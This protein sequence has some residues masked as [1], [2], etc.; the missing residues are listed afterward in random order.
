MAVSSKELGGASRNDA[1]SDI[2]MSVV[3]LGLVGALWLG[4][5]YFTN[6]AVVA[7]LHW[8]GYAYD[9]EGW[10]WY[11]VPVAFSI[12]E[13]LGWERRK[14]LPGWVLWLA[15]T[16]A[17]LDFATSVYG[18]VIAVGGKVVPLMN[19]YTIPSAGATPVV[20]GI[21]VSVI[22]TFPPERVTMGSILMIRKSLG[23]LQRIGF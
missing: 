1:I 15:A 11:I 7:I 6:Q 9:L 8:F 2:V 13:I 18:V 23:V 19:G 10:H 3:S 16:V 14:V 21:M 20:I 22:L 5:A 4:G 12:V 17:G